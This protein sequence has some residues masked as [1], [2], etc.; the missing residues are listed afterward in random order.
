M[1]KSPVPAPNTPVPSPQPKWLIDQ[2]YRIVLG[3][4]ESFWS[5][6]GTQTNGSATALWNAPQNAQCHP[7]V[8]QTHS[9]DL[10]NFGDSRGVVVT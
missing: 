2:A 5:E 3:A 7:N 4:S 10:S 8:V 9:F 1:Y 6:L